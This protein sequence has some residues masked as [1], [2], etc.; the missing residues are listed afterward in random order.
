MEIENLLC[1]EEAEEFDKFMLRLMSTTLS[2]DILHPCSQ[3]LCVV[4]SKTSSRL[5][6]YASFHPVMLF[7]CSKHNLHL[8]LSF[9]HYS[10]G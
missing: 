2:V 8:N 3:I 9:S 6:V 1:E 5:L 7:D 10:N 4:Y